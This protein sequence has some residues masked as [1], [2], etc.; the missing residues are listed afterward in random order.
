MDADVDEEPDWSSA[1][2]IEPVPDVPSA[3]TQTSWRPT[4][5][6]SWTPTSKA[7]SNQP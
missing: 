6:S 3:E 2:R 1:T 4:T 5:C 7:D